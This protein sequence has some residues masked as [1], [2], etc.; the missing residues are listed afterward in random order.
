MDAEKR[1]TGAGLQ[2][3]D[4]QRQRFH[5]SSDDRAEAGALLVGVSGYKPGVRGVVGGCNRA[6]RGGKIMQQL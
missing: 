4:R 2:T 5:Q 1:A 6:R 3:E